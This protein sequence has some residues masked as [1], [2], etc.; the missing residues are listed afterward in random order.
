MEVVDPVAESMEYVVEAPDELA[1]VFEEAD[2]SIDLN[3]NKAIELFKSVLQSDRPD[4]T[5]VR[6][7]EQ[8]VVK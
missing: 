5:A 7:K 2:D 8:S 6:L 4:E 1:L 3:Q